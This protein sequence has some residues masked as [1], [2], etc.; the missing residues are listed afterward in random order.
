MINIP[1]LKSFSKQDVLQAIKNDEI[2]LIS[3]IS[4]H[5]F[6]IL[7]REIGD[8]NDRYGEFY[9]VVDTG[10]DYKTTNIPIS[11]TREDTGVHTDSSARDYCP[12]YLSLFCANQGA[13]GGE[14]YFVDMRSVFNDL[15]KYRPELL[16]YLSQD[17]YRD[18]VTPGAENNLENV[19]RNKFPIIRHDDSG[20]LEFRYMRYWIER[21]YKKLSLE[22]DLDSAHLDLLD[23]GQLDLL[24]SYLMNDKYRSTFML[25][26]NQAVIFKNSYFP[27]GRTKYEENKLNRRRLIRVWFDR[28]NW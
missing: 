18:V 23:S 25:K 5:E 3:E 14:S 28:M 6:K 2:V 7:C 4:E 26:N 10:E 11:Q 17:F 15:K 1:T 22:H 20:L 13:F 24:D 19:R 21:A 8:L 27:H 16:K 9:D 12:E